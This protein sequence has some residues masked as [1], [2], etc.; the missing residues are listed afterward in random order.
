MRNWVL[1]MMVL[2]FTMATGSLNGQKAKLLKAA[3]F[4]EALEYQ[5]AITLYLQILEKEDQPEAMGNLAKAY[6]KINDY[7]NAESWYA[8]LVEAQEVDPLHHY[9]YGL[10][11]L[12]KGDCEAAASQFN[13][14]LK[15]KPFDPRKR[16][17]QNICAYKNVL[18]E[19]NKDQFEVANLPFNSPEQELGPALYL[20]GLVFGSLQAPAGSDK[21]DKHF[22]DLQFAPFIHENDGPLDP[23]H[24]GNA[25]FFS[26]R[27]HFPYHEAIV[28]FSD[29]L[30]EIFL[31]RNNQ[32]KR[33]PEE[34]GLVRLEI[35]YATNLGGDTW[36][37]LY[38]LPFN[39]TEYS[40]AHPSL[41]PDG[42]RL[43]FSS[44]MP[45]GY[46]GKDLY[47]AYKENGEWGKPINL[48]PEINT[49]GDELYPFYH[50][51]GRLYF[52]SDGHPGLG[53]Q[54]I[55]YTDE[56][57]SGDWKEVE[58]PGMPINSMYDDYG[59]ILSK[60]GHYGYFTS[61]RAGGVGADDIYGFQKKG[62]TLE[63]EVVDANSGSLLP[64]AFVNAC[65]QF[66][67]EQQEPGRFKLVLPPGACCQITA[68]GD[69]FLPQTEKICADADG[70]AKVTRVKM[71]LQPLERVSEWVVSGKVYNQFNGQPLTGAKVVLTGG[72]CED[73]FELT[74]DLDGVYHFKA[75][76][77]C[78]YLLRVEKNGYFAFASK[79]WICPDQQTADK[80]IM[81]VFLQPYTQSA[82]STGT[83]P[84]A[85]AEEKNQ[86]PKKEEPQ[87]DKTQTEP[88]KTSPPVTITSFEQGDSRYDE[89][90]SITYLLNVYYEVNRSSVRKESVP[91]LIKLHRVLQDNPDLSIEIASHTDSRGSEKS[92]E[93]LSQRRAE[94]I[95]RYLIEKGISR[96]RLRAKGYGESRPVND[97]ID[98]KECEEEAY[99]MNRRTEFRVMDK[100]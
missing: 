20:N 77:G 6:R 41:T 44:D 49:D 58:N 87:P 60:E 31:T 100:S 73:I 93:I 14:F 34:L 88:Q 47:L 80:V 22:F 5:K 51:D 94:A 84:V 21:K 38:P 54:D 28:A 55:F 56:T 98:G 50:T 13:H 72:Q 66:S 61:N 82:Q 23:F 69:G 10:I 81:D 37:E 74:T 70:Q 79:D 19:N 43:F 76:T 83:Q 71:A 30:S 52:A 1:P 17:L 53:G 9:Y 11:L 16:R 42:K 90:G 7:A 57:D 39:S 68:G 86:K 95:V 4:M 35:M 91:E 48:G 12:R 27:L 62:V 45:G 78:C 63:I 97:C 36:S 25:H 24:F 3:S 59:L 33:G 99:Q 75:R 96:T 2:F 32:I 18:L 26:E 65:K 92:N 40:V 15:L 64:D 8:R 46:G 67:F 29:D 85:A 89:D